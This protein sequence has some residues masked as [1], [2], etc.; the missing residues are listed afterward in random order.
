MKV[1]KPIVP[2]LHFCFRWS[3]RE[4]PNTWT[5]PTPSSLS[6]CICWDWDWEKL[7]S[8]PVTDWIFWWFEGYK[9]RKLWFETESFLSRR[10]SGDWRRIH[11]ETVGWKYWTEGNKGYKYPHM[12]GIFYL[13]WAS[14]VQE[15]YWKQIFIDKGVNPCNWWLWEENKTFGG[16]VWRS[17]EERK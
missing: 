7:R 9:E 14:P 16:S 10:T 3:A 1:E 2:F 15:G 4:Y 12:I 17:G 11:E 5:T 13:D 6:N 8:Y